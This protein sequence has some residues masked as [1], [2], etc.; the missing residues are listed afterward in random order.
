MLLST[1]LFMIYIENKDKKTIE[2][3]KTIE[4]NKKPL[5]I[6]FFSNL[7]MLLFGFLGEINK[8]DKTISFSLGSICFQFVIILFIK[9]S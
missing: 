4:E 1:I 2:F 8:L 6:V 5:L 3:K 9:I 7:L